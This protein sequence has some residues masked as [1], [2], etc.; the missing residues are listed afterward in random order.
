MPA[1]APGGA[2]GPWR[3]S[4][5]RR[6][7]CADR[8][9]RRRSC[10]RRR[11]RPPSR[12]GRG[13][14]SAAG[15]RA[16]HRG[17]RVGVA[18]VV[19]AAEDGLLAVAAGR[20]EQPE[21][22]RQLLDRVQ[23]ARDA[24]V[25]RRRGVVLADRVERRERTPQLG[26]A[27]VAPAVELRGGV[28]HRLD[29][30]PRAV[31]GEREARLDHRLRGRVDLHRR[32]DGGG[33]HARGLPAVAGLVRRGEIERLV[34]RAPRIAGVRDPDRR[35]VH[36]RAAVDDVADARVARVGVP[37][38]E[39]EHEPLLGEEEAVVEQVLAVE[40]RDP[41]LLVDDRRHDQRL[42]VVRVQVVPLEVVGVD[43]HARHQ[44]VVGDVAVALVERRERLLHLL[45]PPDRLDDPG[46]PAAEMGLDLVRLPPLGRAAERVADGCA[47]QAADGPIGQQISTHVLILDSRSSWPQPAGRNG[48]PAGLGVSY[49]RTLVQPSLSCLP[50]SSSVIAPRRYWTNAGWATSAF[51]RG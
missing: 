47:R 17:D 5:R 12:G 6:Q 15:E 32:G 13:F 7:P 24:S 22:D 41:R 21:C 49:P 1:P 11:R 35:D 27:A 44:R 50:S 48:R 25:Q 34:V 31:L 20:D 2:E 19:D 16:A 8:R 9:P 4:P 46:H 40:L 36:R 45:R 43:E 42:D 26:E 3:R 23:P 14:P 18:A 51:Q 39:L 38:A 10:S 29:R 30:R 28:R 33:E 37:V